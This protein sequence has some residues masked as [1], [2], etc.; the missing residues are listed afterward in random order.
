MKVLTNKDFAQNEIQNAVLHRLAAA[1]SS[2]V[3]GQYYYN[4]TSNTVQYYDGSAWQTVNDATNGVTKSSNATAASI[5]QLSGGAD[6]TIADYVPGSAGIVKVDS[7]GRPS[8]ATSS[9]DYAPATS[10]SSAL[11][12]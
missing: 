12:G 2:P 3:R 4:T 5:L 8:I 11:K 10:G 6:K 1:P 9:S 7:T